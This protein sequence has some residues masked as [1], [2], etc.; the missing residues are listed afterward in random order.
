MELVKLEVKLAMN[1]KLEALAFIKIILVFFN[2]H[3]TYL[4]SLE[5]LTDLH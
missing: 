5:N 4:E 2:P 3:T 1:G